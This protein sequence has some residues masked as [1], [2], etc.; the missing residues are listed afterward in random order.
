MWKYT[1]EN[2]NKAKEK[3]KKL[4]PH[5]NML[6]IPF[7]TWIINHMWA[8][9]ICWTL[10]LWAFAG[11][12]GW[13]AMSCIGMWHVTTPT[14]ALVRPVLFSLVP[15]LRVDAEDGKRH[16]VA[17]RKLPQQFASTWWGVMLGQL[18]EN[19]LSVH[20]K[21]EPLV[22]GPMPTG[23]RLAIW[24]CGVLD[25]VQLFRRGLSRIGRD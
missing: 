7:I 10:A 12:V 2:A 24:E 25:L 4:I 13:F 18:L 19:N 15:D 22:P 3:G 5:V 11:H 14:V 17:I 16:Q 23:L 21:I 6:L 20:L 8:V 9:S 1:K